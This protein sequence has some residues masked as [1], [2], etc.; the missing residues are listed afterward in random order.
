ME[1]A[2]A[3][4]LFYPPGHPYPQRSIKHC[5]VFERRTS[6]MATFEK[7]IFINAPVG[8]VYEYTINPENWSHFYN[9]LS[10]AES[11]HGKGEV[12]TIVKS[13]YSMMGMHFPITIEVTESQLTADGAIWKGNI[14]GSFPTKQ[15]SRYIAK[16]GG[17]ELT[18]DIDSVPPETLFTKILDKLV[19][20]KME[21]NSTQH[22]LENIKAICESA[23]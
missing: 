14:T 15:T 8:K 12:G 17:T 6:I 16:D 4:F 7:T 3:K 9:G 5:M 19:T 11:V 20:D 1:N 23:Q 2:S 10:E 21:E 18:F 13:S 22:T